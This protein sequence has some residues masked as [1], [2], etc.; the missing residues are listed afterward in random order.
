M[1]RGAFFRDIRPLFG[2]RLTQSQVE[3]LG[4]LLD[5]W[6]SGYRE[7]TSVPQFAYALGTA[8]HETAA[9]MQPIKE[10]G[11]SD[12][13]FKRYDPNGAKP[14]IAK[15]LGNTRAGDG[16]K[17]AGRGYVQLTGRRNYTNAANKLGIDFVK[18]PDAVMQP[19]HAARVLFEGME[20]GWFTGLTLDRAIDD[21]CNGD[22][23][24]DFIFARRII[25]GTDKAAA[26]AEH[27]VKFLK[28][29]LAATAA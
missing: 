18:S 26:I 7:R 8:Y 22:E 25:N 1:N 17:F 3:G 12:Y 13:F 19:E 21:K 4:T 29:L 11:G 24:A 9:T 14:Q 27:A 6:E 28:A 15:A 2:G 10:R 20:E 16:V 23:L 5:A